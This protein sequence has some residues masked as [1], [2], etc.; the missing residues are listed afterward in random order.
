MVYFFH[1]Y[2]E[3]HNPRRSP[4]FFRGASSTT[5]LIEILRIPLKLVVRK[6]AVYRVYITGKPAKND[7]KTPCLMGKTMENLF[8]LGK[9]MENH[10]F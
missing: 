3:C 9:T 4:S 7:G 10:H 1:S 5:N 6:T 2:W 8:F